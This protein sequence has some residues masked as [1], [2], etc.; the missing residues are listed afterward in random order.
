MID[1][2]DFI[3][4]KII[5]N[6]SNTLLTVVKS[7]QNNLNIEVS[8]FNLTNIKLKHQNL[9]EELL[10]RRMKLYENNCPIKIKPTQY[11]IVRL[12]GVDFKNYTR[13]F[14]KPLDGNFAKVM[15]MVLNK[16]VDKFNPKVGFTYSDEISL[17]FSSCNEFDGRSNKI[18]SIMSSFCS[19]TFNKLIVNIIS[20]DIANY[21]KDF[22]SFINNSIPIF[23]TSI[24][25]FSPEN[26]MEI[27]RYFVLKSNIDSRRQCLK[28]YAIHYIGEEAIKNKNVLQLRAELKKIG[29]DYINSV[30][31]FLRQ[32]IYSK[33]INTNT[34]ANTEVVNFTFKME[35]KE[36]YLKLLIE[37]QTNIQR[38]GIE[39]MNILSIK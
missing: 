22:E 20:K 14:G 8:L 35:S 12:S 2:K 33:K 34:E 24:I 15:I 3:Y 5:N 29:F 11:F 36:N 6:E 26:I 30:P 37:N 13:Q 18:C 23:D 21:S 25:V 17:V 4:K 10:E 28:E 32:G 7:L 9:M 39:D 27:T 16:M 19:V 1:L 38:F 31:L